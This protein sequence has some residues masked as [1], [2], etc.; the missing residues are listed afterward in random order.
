MN[1]FAAMKMERQCPPMVFF[2]S[3]GSLLCICSSFSLSLLSYLYKDVSNEN[4]KECILIYNQQMLLLTKCM[5][6]GSS[7]E[8]KQFH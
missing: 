5:Q 6:S 4:K 3:V 7:A 1:D 2:P 8:I